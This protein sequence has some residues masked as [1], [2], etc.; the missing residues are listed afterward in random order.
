M[1]Q[2]TIG[3]VKTMSA[4]NYYRVCKHP[5]GGFTAIMGFMSNEERPEPR[6]SSPQF[7]T[8]QE[9]YTYADRDAI[10]EYGIQVDPDCRDS[11]DDLSVRLKA[12]AR[13]CVEHG[14]MTP[15]AEQMLHSILGAYV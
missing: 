9:A 14:D 13:D 2:R 3:D 15:S 11:V 7:D 4:D 1:R 6:D 10:I 5:K 8:W 12:F